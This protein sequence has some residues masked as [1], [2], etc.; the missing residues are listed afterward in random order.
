[1][2]LAKPHQL[3]SLPVHET[4]SATDWQV[5]SLTGLVERSLVPGARALDKPPHTS[6]TAD[7]E[8]E[9][10]WVARDQRWK[11]PSVA[12]LL[13]MTGTWSAARYVVFASGD[14]TICPT[15][16]E[17]A[18]LRPI[19]AVRLNG[20]TL[21]RLRGGPCRLIVPGRPSHHSVKWVN[22]I[23]VAADLEEWNP[24]TSGPPPAGP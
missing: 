10:S 21:E 23:R 2:A 14:Y 22:A 5:L 7:F 20:A 19:L 16:G 3:E 9:E 15:T 24:T 13:E 4:G 6:R 1:M 11:G 17:G 8:C 12:S 18:A